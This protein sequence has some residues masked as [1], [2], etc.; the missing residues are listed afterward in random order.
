MGEE[1]FKKMARKEEPPTNVAPAVPVP[2]STTLDMGFAHMLLKNNYFAWL[3]MAK[4]K[5]KDRLLTDYDA[6]QRLEG[7]IT[8]AEHLLGNVM[9][10]L[11]QD[12]H[13]ANQQ[14]Y[15]VTPMAPAG[16]GDG[17]GAAGEDERYDEVKSAFVT[18]TDARRIECKSSQEAEKLQETLLNLEQE[19]G[20]GELMIEVADKRAHAQKRRKVLKDLKF[21][22]V[23]QNN[24][25]KFRGWSS[26]AHSDL[27][28]TMAAIDGEVNDT[29]KFEKAFRK[30]FKA[31]NESGVA[32]ASEDAT[33][34]LN[35]T[36][37]ATLWASVWAQV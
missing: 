34:K 36:H 5:L 1:T 22:T 2:M 35:D 13:T 3:L 8:L 17:E 14:Q 21:Y 33:T 18:R 26:R 11:E 4:S 15:L 10:D 12:E 20:D 6:S 9:F 31:A 37:K 19:G 7:K 16:D 24:E 29:I 28:D 25:R 27:A 32:D 23:A 30:L